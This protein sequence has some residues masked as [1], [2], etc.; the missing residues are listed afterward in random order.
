MGGGKENIYMGFFGHLS[1]KYSSS[2]THKV[3]LAVDASLLLLFLFLLILLLLLVL[4]GDDVVQVAEVMLGE[5]VVHRLSHGDQR[6]NLRKRKME[7]LVQLSHADEPPVQA[8][9]LG[10]PAA[11]HD[12]EDDGSHCRLEDPQECQTQA[13]DEGEEVDTSLG[14]VPQVDQ[15]RLVF[16]RH[17]EQ[18]QTVHKLKKH[19]VSNFLAIK[20]GSK[21]TRDD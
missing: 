2:R 16:G 8:A 7:G 17:Q 14:D 12:G 15:V 4:L 9:L 5:H 13:L 6:Q 19:N 20:K 11:H 21:V 3:N 18:L 1:T 10:A